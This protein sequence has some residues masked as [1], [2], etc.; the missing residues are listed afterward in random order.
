M[1][2]KTF[3]GTKDGKQ[4]KH[5]TSFIIVGA[6]IHTRGKKV[7][8]KRHSRFQAAEVVGKGILAQI[9]VSAT[10]A[11]SQDMANGCRGNKKASG[12]GGQAGG[13]GR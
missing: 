10:S 6:E 2:E 5:V 3:A 7:A 4:L 8:A 11:V 12:G 1:L 9:V 13:G